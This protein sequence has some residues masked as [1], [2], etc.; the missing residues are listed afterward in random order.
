MSRVVTSRWSWALLE[1]RIVCLSDIP[2]TCGGSSYA[3]TASE[4]VVKCLLHIVSY[5]GLW[6]PNPYN[7]TVAPVKISGPCSI[8]SPLSV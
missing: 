2:T 5:I 7:P 3:L 8:L 4:D 6:P 1:M